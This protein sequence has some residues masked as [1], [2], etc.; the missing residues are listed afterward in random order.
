MSDGR[1][2]NIAVTFQVIDRVRETVHEAHAEAALRVRGIELWILLNA[3][4][5]C[6]NL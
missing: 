4:A 1:D 2:P 3:L 6:L 5:S